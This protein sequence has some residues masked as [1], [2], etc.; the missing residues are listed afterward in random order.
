MDL[1]EDRPPHDADAPPPRPFTG[2]DIKSFVNT[3]TKGSKLG[4]GAC[5][6]ARFFCHLCPCRS[7]E[8]SLF[9]FRVGAAR[10]RMCVFNERERYQHRKVDSHAQVAMNAQELFN[11]LDRD[12]SA[13]RVSMD[14]AFSH[15][16][17]EDT[18]KRLRDFQQDGP[19]PVMVKEDAD[20]CADFIA[21][22]WA[23]TLR[24][25]FDSEG[26]PTRKW[27]YDYCRFVQHTEELVGG[28]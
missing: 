3:V 18:P 25:E 15:L 10:C 21:F 16:N 1:P 26:K 8:A 27:L 6:V 28:E 2:D 7:D 13:R 22:G 19:V 5:K 11:L 12:V 24:N 20:F 9:A 17:Y 4:G 14:E 23:T